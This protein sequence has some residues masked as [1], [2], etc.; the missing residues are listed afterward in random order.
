MKVQPKKRARKPMEKMNKY[1]LEHGISY[2][3]LKYD[4]I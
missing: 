4:G 1:D 3:I 2:Y